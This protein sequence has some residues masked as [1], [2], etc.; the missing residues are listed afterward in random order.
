[1]NK[2][3]GAGWQLGKIIIAVVLLIA[4][5]PFAQMIIE[6]R[7]TAA[8][9]ACGNGKKASCTRMISEVSCPLDDFTPKGDSKAPE[10]HFIR[11]DRMVVGVRLMPTLVNNIQITSM[12]TADWITGG[13]PMDKQQIINNCKMLYVCFNGFPEGNECF[14][15]LPTDNE[16]TCGVQF[17]EGITDEGTYQ[18]ILKNKGGSVFGMPL[19][20]MSPVIPEDN[21]YEECI[22]VLDDKNKECKKAAEQKCK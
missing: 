4:L 6:G 10:H 12:Q 19:A 21:S 16:D 3:G 1:M 7:D 2:K 14:P 11:N 18:E 17:M 20:W 5:L 9:F 22:I 15:A 13:I 8:A